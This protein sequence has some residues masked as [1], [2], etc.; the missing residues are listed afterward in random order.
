MS[1]CRETGK[2]PSDP[3]K[4]SDWPWRR[5]GQSVEAP[6][7]STAGDDGQMSVAAEDFMNNAG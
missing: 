7:A 4:H 1:L 6:G 5:T 3:G 2:W